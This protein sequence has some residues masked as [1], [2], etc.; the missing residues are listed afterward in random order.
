MQ[1]RSRLSVSSD[2][3]KMKNYGTV[4]AKKFLFNSN[5]QSMDEWTLNDSS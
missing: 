1:Q 5:R 4:D 3:K 2:V